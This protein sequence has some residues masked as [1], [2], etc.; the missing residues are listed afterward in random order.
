MAKYSFKPFSNKDGK[1]TILAFI[2]TFITLFVLML[3][4]G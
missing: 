4:F 3:C 2:I 1:L